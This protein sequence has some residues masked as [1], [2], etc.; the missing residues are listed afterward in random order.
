[1]KQKQQ[2]VSWVFSV[3]VQQMAIMNTYLINVHNAMKLYN[4]N[5]GTLDPFLYEKCHDMF[6]SAIDSLNTI[7]LDH[8]ELISRVQEILDS[9]QS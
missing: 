2:N 4:D 3:V 7:I 8:V 6:V 5:K 1:V 9:I